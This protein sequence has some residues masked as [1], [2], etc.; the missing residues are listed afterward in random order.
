MLRANT[1]RAEAYLEAA[2]AEMTETTVAFAGG[3]TRSVAVTASRA[4]I[5]GEVTSI[6]GLDPD[7][8]LEGW[9]YRR[10]HS[11]DAD[12]DSVMLAGANLRDGDWFC[13]DG[14][15]LAIMLRY[16]DGSYDA[17]G[18][19]W[20][21]E[22]LGYYDSY[23]Q[24]VWDWYVMENGLED[25]ASALRRRLDGAPERR[26]RDARQFRGQALRRRGLVRL[27]ARKPLASQ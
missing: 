22:G 15:R 2:A 3:E 7:G 24:Y 10:W 26:R 8:T 18:D 4:D 21:S 14:E 25:E 20:L 6:E 27:S 16:P 13:F 9:I 19:V 17:L 11:L 12:A 1:P 23:Y 5:D